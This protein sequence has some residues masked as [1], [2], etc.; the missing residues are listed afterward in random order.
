MNIYLI[1][2]L[3][4]LILQGI[5][6]VLQLINDKNP[7][8][9]K[10]AEGMSQ[11]LQMMLMIMLMNQPN[12]MGVNPMMGMMPGTQP[13]TTPVNPMEGMFAELQKMMGGGSPN[14]IQDTTVETMK[15]EIASLKKELKKAKKK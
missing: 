7:T 15:K 14:P 13:V 3:L 4:P 1:L 2:Q 6:G 8:P 11:L 5:T 9:E 10:S 12:N